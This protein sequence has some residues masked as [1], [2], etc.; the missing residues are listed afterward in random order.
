MG[1]VWCPDHPLTI[2]KALVCQKFLEDD[3]RIFEKDP[4]G[5][6]KRALTGVLITSGLGGAL[7]GEEANRM[8]LGVIRKHWLEAISHREKP[9]VPLGMVGR[10]KRQ[11]GEKMFIQPLTVRSV[12][13]LEYRLWMY[14][15]ITEFDR[16]GIQTGP[17][18]RVTDKKDPRQYKRAK[19]G[20][21]DSLLYPLLRR[22]QEIHPDFIGEEVNVEDEYSVSRSL[23]RGATSQVRNQQIPQ[24]VIEANNR[25]RQR[26]KARGATP[27]MSLLERYADAR[28]VVPLLVRF[29]ES[30]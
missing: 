29:S 3:W 10:F 13:G 30:L 16:Q 18:F 24:D 11:V 7:R 28:A 22:V 14:R 25:W 15:M 21:L 19:V 2:H 27:H 5:R 17:V 26:E 20:D 6:L 4:T 8:E 12:S 23:K 1:D 9:H